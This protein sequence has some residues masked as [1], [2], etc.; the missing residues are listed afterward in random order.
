MD[1]LPTPL[2]ASDLT[3]EIPFV[4]DIPW[5]FQDFETFPTRI[6]A[7]M[8]DDG[9]PLLDMI[10]PAHLASLLQSWLYF[11]FLSEIFGTKLRREDFCRLRP[12]NSTKPA[13]AILD[14]T[15]LLRLIED[16]LDDKRQLARSE[17]G[18]VSWD[19][20]KAEKNIYIGTHTTKIPKI[21]AD[22]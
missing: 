1:H 5:D 8:D 10:S 21:S 3:I 14:S 11:G 2:N 18:F 22:L 17:R 7:A 19:Y 4:A 15:S 9:Q 13:R 6:G 20:F 16:L 12:A